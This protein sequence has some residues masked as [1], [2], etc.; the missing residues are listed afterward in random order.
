MCRHYRFTVK[1]KV[2]PWG[3]V[4]I[5]CRTYVSGIAPRDESGN[6]AGRLRP[7][8]KSLLRDHDRIR[9]LFMACRSSTRRC[10]PL[11]SARLR[12]LLSHDLPHLGSCH[13]LLSVANMLCQRIVN[14]RLM[15]SSAGAW[16]WKRSAWI[17]L[18]THWTPKAKSANFRTLINQL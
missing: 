13:R 3:D 4:K 5:R 7:H 12:Q 8:K 17:K 11:T 2:A 18:N 10:R 15:Q 6:A 1:G 14:E 9:Y 16:R